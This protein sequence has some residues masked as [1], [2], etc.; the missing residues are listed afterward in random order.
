MIFF[1]CYIFLKKA[2]NINNHHLSMIQLSDKRAD[3]FSKTNNFT[4]LKK[5]DEGL[6]EVA[7]LN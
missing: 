7:T 3:T 1:N 5:Y 4:R 6:K 2:I